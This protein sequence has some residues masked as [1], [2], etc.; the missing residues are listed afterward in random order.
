[1]KIQI[2]EVID[3]DDCPEECEDDCD[4]CEIL[5]QREA[6]EMRDCTML[7]H[8]S[9]ITPMVRQSSYRFV[10]EAIHIA[11]TPIVFASHYSY[12]DYGDFTDE[13]PIYIP[14]PETF[15]HTV[16]RAGWVV[17]TTPMCD[18]ITQNIAHKLCA[19]YY[20]EGTVSWTRAYLRLIDDNNNFLGYGA[21]CGEFSAEYPI[22]RRIP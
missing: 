21:I 9:S 15:G 2:T 16:V 12:F 11:H 6:E 13:T 8:D 5:E 18:K 14:I 22:R 17:I 7:F 20:C 1:M 10:Q 19:R 3:I 4:C